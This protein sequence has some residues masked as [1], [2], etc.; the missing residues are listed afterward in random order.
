LFQRRLHVLLVIAV[1]AAYGGSQAVAMAH[2]DRSGSRIH[3]H[4]KISWREHDRVVYAVSTLNAPL[5]PDGRQL[6]AV[7]WNDDAARLFYVD[8]SAVDKQLYY[9][10]VRSAV[11]AVLSVYAYRFGWKLPEG[12]QNY[13]CVAGASAAVVNGYKAHQWRR[14]AQFST[15]LPQG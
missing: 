8:K 1:F 14:E 10:Q 12:V 7:L 11:R 5:C 9:I 6:S 13:K 4:R 15:T 2:G 3:H